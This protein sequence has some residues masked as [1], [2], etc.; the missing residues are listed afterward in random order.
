MC[1]KGY[2]A[3][4]SRYG[5]SEELLTDHCQKIFIN[6]DIVLAGA[7]SG[8]ECERF[9]REDFS[10]LDWSNPEF[11]KAW[12]KRYLKHITVLMYK[13]GESN[14]IMT[15][16]GR[17]PDPV[18]LYEEPIAIGSGSGFAKSAAFALE[19]NVKGIKFTPRQI[20]V[21]SVEA[22]INFD[23]NSGGRVHVVNL[24]KFKDNPW[25]PGSFIT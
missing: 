17:Y 14:M 13:R 21:A 7:G 22:A 6:N 4:D 8:G 19:N 1:Y 18:P 24:M 15:S 9:L 10:F 11:P 3:A 12:V 5:Y 25:P 20:A 2:L 23:F 16:E